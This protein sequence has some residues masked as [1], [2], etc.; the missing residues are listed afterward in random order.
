MNLPEKTDTGVMA[1]PAS[2][3]NSLFQFI[4]WVGSATMVSIA[5]M[6]L[7]DYG[8]DIGAGAGYKYELRSLLHITHRRR[9]LW[10]H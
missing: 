7:G 4:R 2:K 8:T 1:E 3:R 10:E 5:Y 9:S 6:D